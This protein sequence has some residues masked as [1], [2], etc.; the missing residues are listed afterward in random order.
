MHNHGENDQMHPGHLANIQSLNRGGSRSSAAAFLENANRNKIN[1][2]FD[3]MS[4]HSSLARGHEQDDLSHGNIFG[5]Q[6]SQTP[7]KK[8]A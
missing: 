5:D 7:V 4:R 2:A 6:F 1:N 3:I 8:T